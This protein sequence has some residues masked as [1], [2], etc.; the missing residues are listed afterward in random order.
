KLTIES[1]EFGP[2]LVVQ[3][4]VPFGLKHMDH[5][6]EDVQKLIMQQLETILPGLPQP[7]ATKCHKWTYSQVTNSVANTPGQMTLHL[8]PFLVCGGD[9]FTHSNFDGCI[10]SALSVMKVLKRYI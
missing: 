8:K 10:T 2:S 5:S 7:I 9:G 6:K 3:T 4:S 1:S